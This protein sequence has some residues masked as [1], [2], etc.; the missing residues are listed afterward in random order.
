MTFAL[1][2]E[3][4]CCGNSGVFL[5][6]QL[7]REVS[8]C[9]SA[10]GCSLLSCP[11]RARH[12]A[13]H[14]SEASRGLTGDGPSHGETLFFPP[15]ATLQKSLLSKETSDGV[16]VAF[17]CIAHH[18][19]RTSQR[20]CFFPRSSRFWG[21]PGCLGVCHWGSLRQL[22]SRGG[23]GRS[24][25]EKVSALPLWR[26]GRLPT[27][28]APSSVAGGVQACCLQEPQVAAVSPAQIALGVT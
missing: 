25:G 26:L 3:P 7:I 16:P 6:L 1:S 12:R 9:F 5:F 18:A 20:Q 27:S 10:R 24:R 11:F 28:G 22:Q 21:W 4:K 19:R 2:P 8:V 13:G 17:P 23:W 14:A 15:G